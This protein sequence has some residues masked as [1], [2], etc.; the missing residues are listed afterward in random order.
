M[1]NQAKITNLIIRLIFLAVLALGCF[2]I[3]QPFFGIVI[4][5]AILATSI[6]PVMEWL[7]V[8]LGGRTKLAVTLLVLVGIAIIIGPIT[9]LATILV[10]NIQELVKQL[11]ADSITVPPPPPNLKTWPVIG[12]PLNEIWQSASGNLEEVLERFSPQIKEIITKLLAI[13]ANTSLIVLQFLFSIIIA[14]VLLLN[15]KAINRGLTRFFT[16]LVPTQGE[17]FLELSAATI[18]GVSRGVIGV[19]LIQ[20]LLIGIGM[21]VAKVPAAGLLTLICLVLTIIQIG[22]GLVVI[23]TII[24]AWTS[25]GTLGAILYTAWMIPCLIVDNFLKPMLMGQGLPV[26]TLVVFIGVIGGT[27]S[28]G[29]LGLFIGPVI[30]SLGYEILVAWINE[31]E[32]QKQAIGETE[33]ASNYEI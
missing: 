8:R 19:A 30:L 23:P 13:A 25:M 4:W 32:R 27:L 22:P 21:A 12:Q 14:A 5:G 24:W 28:N 6:Y 29:I 17:V 7:K 15:T 3:L 31:P 1:D 16:K 20:A 10:D 11:S 33:V 26:P 2:R 9:Y 18:R